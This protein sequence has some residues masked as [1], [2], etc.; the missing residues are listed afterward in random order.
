MFWSAL[1]SKIP[2]FN[3]SILIENIMKFFALYIPFIWG[4]IIISS[5]HLL[6][7]TECGGYDW[8][9][10]PKHPEMK[11]DIMKPP[12]EYPTTGID[13]IDMVINKLQYMLSWVGLYNYQRDYRVSPFFQKTNSVFGDYFVDLIK[14]SWSGMREFMFFTYRYINWFYPIDNLNEDNLIVFNDQGDFKHKWKNL[15]WKFIKGVIVLNIAPYIVYFTIFASV[16]IGFIS[17]LFECAKQRLTYM[18]VFILAVLAILIGLIVAV[19]QVF[20][21]IKLTF[22]SLYDGIRNYKYG[23]WHVYRHFWFYYFWLFLLASIVTPYIGTNKYQ[24]SN[25]FWIWISFFII[26]VGV[27]VGVYRKNKYLKR[28]F[29]GDCI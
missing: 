13:H 14:A 16:I 24:L 17:L 10:I 9:I 6:S 5:A 27:A 1:L 15:I 4:A 2:V 12:Y 8:E 20:T 29:L 21:N 11:F 28:L 26:H 3:S 23:F 19:V 22:Y 25:D 7:R 18:S